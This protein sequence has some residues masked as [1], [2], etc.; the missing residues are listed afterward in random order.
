MPSI[1]RH[2]T[3]LTLV[4]L[5]GCTEPDNGT[6]ILTQQARITD[7]QHDRINRHYAYLVDVQDNITR[8]YQIGAYTQK[9]VLK[10]TERLGNTLPSLNWRL[11]VD[12]AIINLNYDLFMAELQPGQNKPAIQGLIAHELA[13]AQH[14]LYF[15]ARELLLLGFRYRSYESHHADS[16]WAEWVRSYE[17]FTD[18]QAIAYGYATPLI[19]QKYKTQEYLKKEASPQQHYAFSAYL[20]PEQILR[21]QADPNLFD[22]HLTV[23]LKTLEW[24]VFQN[25]ASRF[26]A[27]KKSNNHD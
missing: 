13:H 12:G 9:Y 19:A 3:L 20:T 4:V 24:E 23:L 5:A 11:A 18:M 17:Q 10:Q 2:L 1:K 26:P 22:Q 7:E 8:D 16:P 15:S 6:V 27:Y 21:M 25:I 14:Y